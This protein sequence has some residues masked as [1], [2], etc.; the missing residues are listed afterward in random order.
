MKTPE[1][2]SEHLPPDE[3]DFL[4]D[5]DDGATST[6]MPEPVGPPEPPKPE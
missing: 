4:E 5:E 6:E 2:E 3:D 1:D